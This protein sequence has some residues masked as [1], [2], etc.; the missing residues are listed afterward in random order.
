MSDFENFWDKRNESS[1]VYDF[2]SVGVKDIDEDIEIKKQV[3]FDNQ[4]PIGIK[5]PL[6]LGY[7]ADG[8]LTMHKSLA[9]QIHDNF[10][11]LIL[12]NHG[13]RLG[14]YD[15]GANLTELAH[16]LGAE[17]VDNEAINRIKRATSKYIPFITLRTF[18]S[19]IDNRD[20]Q[21]TALVGLRITYDIPALAITNKALEI[22]L[23]ATG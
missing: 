2:Q 16:E 4:I 12:T 23:H 14:F 10:R 9:E 1:R 6:E 17:D 13:E 20:N 22:I 3:L 21:H 18:E 19:F 15:F 7:G 8:L 11:N 5:T